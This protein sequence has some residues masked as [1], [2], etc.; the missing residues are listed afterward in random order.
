MFKYRL[1]TSIFFIILLTSCSYRAN[2]LK[3]KYFSMYVL[4]KWEVISGNMK[5]TIK[6]DSCVI[7]LNIINENALKNILLRSPDEYLQ[8]EDPN[9]L[10]NYIF[11]DSNSIYTDKKGLVFYENLQNKEVGK[12]KLKENIKVLLRRS[13]KITDTSLNFKDIDYL[14]EFSHLN[15]VTWLPVKLPVYFDKFNFDITNTKLEYRKLY[16]PI[17]HSR[18]RIGYVYHN[19][20]YN[21]TIMAQSNLLDGSNK[22]LGE[23]KEMLNSIIPLKR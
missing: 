20:L 21:Y 12:Y 5:Y 1:Y 4:P 15:Q 22:Y 10:S 3:N 14:C 11:H 17:K 16:Y 19:N 2:D 18:G 8:T 7:E 9:I 6:R 13:V 23:I